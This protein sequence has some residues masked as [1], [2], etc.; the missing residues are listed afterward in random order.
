MINEELRDVPCK[1]VT[2]WFNSKDNIYSLS[3]FSLFC[4]KI[5][6]NKLA[7][8]Q[9]FLNKIISK[10]RTILRLTGSTLTALSFSS[11]NQGAS[12]GSEGFVLLHPRHHVWAESFRRQGTIDEMGD[13][14]PGTPHDVRVV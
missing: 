11:Y 14:P 9:Q 8:T 12:N 3:L 2:R 5:D 6:Y 13:F 1:S 4:L 10:S 7:P